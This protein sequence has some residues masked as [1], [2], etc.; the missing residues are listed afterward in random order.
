MQKTE[1][2]VFRLDGLAEFGIS[3]DLVENQYTLSELLNVRFKVSHVTIS[4]VIEPVDFY[5]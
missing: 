2:D 3:R 4:E 1:V 5:Y